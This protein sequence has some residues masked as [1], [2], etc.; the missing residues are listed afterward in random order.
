MTPQQ[1]SFYDMMWPLAQSAGNSI[2]LDPRLIF[3]QSALETGWGKSAPNNNFFGIKGPGGSQTTQE[4]I[5]GKWQTIQANF[6][7][8]TSAADSVQG[9]TN[10]LQQ[11]PRYKPLLNADGLDAQ[12]AALG[13]SGY[14]T[15][16]GY[17]GKLKS[18]ISGL[19]GSGGQSSGGFFQ[20][21]NCGARFGLVKSG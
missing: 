21:P 4:W 9:Y 5:N 3:A 18:I 13:K 7:G 14:A 16:P 6:R 15:D 20:C 8:Y 10:F 1:Q 12:L 17:I 19:G 2:G 11:N